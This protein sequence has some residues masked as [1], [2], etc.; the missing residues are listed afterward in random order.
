MWG[1]CLIKDVKIEN[2]DIVLDEFVTDI[3]VAT[4]ALS[5]ELGT[6]LGEYPL[7]DEYGTDYEVIQGKVEDDEVVAEISRVV[8]NHEELER[9]GD[10]EIIKDTTLRTMSVY[11]P[12]MSAETEEETALEVGTDGTD[13]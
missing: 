2:G 10:M 9:N 11:V 5:I 6:R 7:D 12:L 8:A 1:C 3:E 4:Q 13:E